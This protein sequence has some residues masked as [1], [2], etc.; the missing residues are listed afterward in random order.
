M[1]L[2]FSTIIFLVSI[3]YSYVN[4][5]AE[6]LNRF[7]GNEQNQNP[8]ITLLTD[9]TPKEAEPKSIFIGL[10]TALN[11]SSFNSS[12]ANSETS[13]SSTSGISF[14]PA[15]DVVY[16]ITPNIGVGAGFKMSTYKTGYVIDNFSA[17][18]TT[19][20]LDIDGDIYFPIYENLSVEEVN[21]IKSFDIPL[22]FRYQM[23]LGKIKGYADFGIQLTS[24]SKVNYTLNGSGTRKGFYPD[25][26]VTLA[27]FPEYN[28]GDL[29][30]SSAEKEELDTPGMAF[31][32][33]ASIG[34][35][36]ELQSNILIKFGVGG[37]YGFSD[38]RPKFS[39]S[40]NN[41][42]SSTYLDKATLINYFVEIGVAYRFSK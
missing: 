15:I 6:S 34:V 12:M 11:I 16:M 7:Q 18:L 3:N 28:Y 10:S 29:T 42:H 20:F 32:G 31:S 40:F 36:Y 21:T 17:T 1:R 13:W 33:I 5:K 41:F 27:D 8:E 2:L 4:A 39:T 35:L 38:S 22:F 37:S 26:Q 23:D 25:L 19:E 24:F 30:Y 9:D 14:S